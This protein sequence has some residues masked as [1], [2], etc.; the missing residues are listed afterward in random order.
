VVIIDDNHLHQQTS[1]RR[2]RRRTSWS[3]STPTKSSSSPT[4]DA[5]QLQAEN[6]D[7]IPDRLYQYNWIATNNYFT[8]FVHHD[9]AAT[10]AV[11]FY[12]H[13]SVLNFLLAVYFVYSDK[14][15]D[16][17]YAPT[18]NSNGELLTYYF[19]G[20]IWKTLCRRLVRRHRP[21]KAGTG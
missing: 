8:V 14:S 16:N 4:S 13:K 7:L 9:L 10:V 19:F 15:A 3:T 18:V 17:F 2:R 6:P 21:H 11:Y 20:K 12:L 1:P 5:T